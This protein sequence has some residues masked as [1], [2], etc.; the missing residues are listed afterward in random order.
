M[1]FEI[2]ADDSGSPAA[3]SNPEQP[4]TNPGTDENGPAWETSKENVKPLRRGRNT[5][6]ISK[7]LSLAKAVV[8]KSSANEELDRKRA[9]VARSH[10]PRGCWH[11]CHFAVR[12][13][14]VR[15]VHL[16]QLL[17]RLKRKLNPWRQKH[18][19]L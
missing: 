15:A 2:F 13:C 18:T 16:K 5:K 17:P 7:G 12:V 1:S 3:Q 19:M 11:R 14:V 8:T 6:N 9:Y 4:A 10:A